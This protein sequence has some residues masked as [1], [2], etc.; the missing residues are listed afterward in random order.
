MYIARDKDGSL[1]LYNEKPI[2][3]EEEND[4]TISSPTDNAVGTLYSTM[5]PSLKWEDEPMEV[6]LVPKGKTN[7]T[8]ITVTRE[9]IIFNDSY[10]TNM[11]NTTA[12]TA[13]AAIIEKWNNICLD[14]VIEEVCELSVDYADTLVKKLKSKEAERRVEL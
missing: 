12:M 9:N 14:S 11:R 1:W 2:R 4:W 10:W 8:D 5:F 7:K 3:N 6:D 13:M